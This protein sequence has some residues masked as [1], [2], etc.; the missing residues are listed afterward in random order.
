MKYFFDTYALIELAKNNP[1][2]SEYSESVVITTVFN[3]AEL[4]YSILRDFNEEKAKTVYNKFKE[5]ANKINDEV[6]FESMK[7]KLQLKKK[8]LSY[9]D[10]IGYTFALKHNLKFL[11]GDKEFKNMDGVEFVQ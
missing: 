9:T 3:L 2:Y 7:L 8:N 4:H 11:T 10:C 5:C 6:I 1:N